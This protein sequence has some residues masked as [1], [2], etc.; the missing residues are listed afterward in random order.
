M[1]TRL[2]DGTRV[3]QAGDREEKAERAN[4]WWEGRINEGEANGRAIVREKI[5]RYTMR[6]RTAQGE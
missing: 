4:M 3:V 5:Y 6:A 1:G 2:W